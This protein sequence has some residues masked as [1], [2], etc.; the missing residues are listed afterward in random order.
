MFRLTC[1]RDEHGVQLEGHDRFRQIPEESFHRARQRLRLEL[2]RIVETGTLNGTFISFKSNRKINQNRFSFFL[3][4][5]LF[6]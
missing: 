2:E 6:L 4:L 3:L 5:F 1:S